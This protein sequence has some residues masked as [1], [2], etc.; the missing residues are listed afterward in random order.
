MVNVYDI[1]VNKLSEEEAEKLLHLIVFPVYQV[2]SLPGNTVMEI[3]LDDDDYTIQYDNDEYV[4]YDADE[5]ETARANDVE[6][7][8]ANY[9]DI[10]PTVWDESVEAVAWKYA[11]TIDESVYEEALEEALDEAEDDAAIVIQALADKA[12]S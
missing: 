11:G 2:E 6:E 10:S 3:V 5:E 1:D 4:L 7:L 12:F 8:F 9:S